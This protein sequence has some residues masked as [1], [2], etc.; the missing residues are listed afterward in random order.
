VLPPAQLLPHLLT[1]L[2]EVRTSLASPSEGLRVRLVRVCGQLSALTAMTLLNAG[3]PRNA[4][5]FWRTA[6]RAVDQV[7]DRSLRALIS[8]R[9]AVFA[10][11]AQRPIE[12]V[13]A[14]ADDAIGVADGVPCAGAAE[15]YG[16]RAQALARLGHHRE[17]REVLDDLS[18]VFTR[19]PDTVRADRVTQWGWAEQRLRHVQSYVHSYAGRVGDATTAHDAALALYPP[20]AHQG[21][22]QVELHRAICLIVA[23]DPAE[24]ARHTVHTIQALPTGH[25]QDGL[26]H[27]TAALA[28][29]LVPDSAR[30]LPAVAQARDLLALPPGG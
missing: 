14:L 10:L 24:G 5:R 13:L 22:A 21:P 30:A 27:R 6:V 7:N 9:R 19:L 11:Y 12:S 26:V 17:A 1:D 8:G 29:D 25:R 18:D 4:N 23:G 20:A 15:G 16:A 28:L 3:D 2:D